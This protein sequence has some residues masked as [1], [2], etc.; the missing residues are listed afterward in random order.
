MIEL[1]LSEAPRSNHEAAFLL[2]LRACP[3]CGELA[4]VDT[5]RSARLASEPAEP[6]RDLVTAACSACGHERRVTFPDGDRVGWLAD[7]AIL[8]R[9]GPSRLISPPQFLAELH[10][11]AALVPATPTHVTH[12]EYLRDRRR[13]YRMTLCANELLRFLHDG[14]DAIAEEHFRTAAARD[15]RDAAPDDY[16]RPQLEAL[17]AAVH[18]QL[19]AYRA[20]G[21]RFKAMKAAWDAANPPPRPPAFSKESLDAHR[22]WARSPADGP[23]AGQQL[24]AEDVAQPNARL[25]AQDLSG[26]VVTRADL[27]GAD[28]SSADV[29]AVRW[30]DVD[31]SRARL[32]SALLHSSKWV[33][34]RFVEAGLALASV[35]DSIVEDCDFS[36]AALP[37]STWFRADL[38]RCRFD[39]AQIADARFDHAVIVDSSFRGAS[40]ATVFDPIH[41]GAAR[42]WFIRCDLRDIDWTGRWFYDT[43]FVDC[44]FAGAHGT[45]HG[46]QNIHL[47]RCA[48]DPGGPALT[49]PELATML[50]VPAERLIDAPDKKPRANERSYARKGVDAKGPYTRYTEEHSP[51]LLAE[52]ARDPKA[53]FPVPWH[54]S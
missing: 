7:P 25:G 16:R 9:E 39:G 48:L 51:L 42:A 1:E 2:S 14:A 29:H 21:P 54:I 24:V 8:G 13:V 43:V 22:T 37:R 4:D 52:R 15:A 6:E 33:R 11:L 34:C 3:Q 12:D 35:G 50:H 36:R 49:V 23:P 27:T 47:L 40:F 10:R 44:L 20:E 5:V 26:S 31:L 46:F 38:A 45:A 30:T 41:G 28:L 19:D 18:Q 53:P 17:H 32:G